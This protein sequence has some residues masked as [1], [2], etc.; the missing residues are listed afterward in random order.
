MPRVS[1]IVAVADNGVIGHQGDL[2]WR[3]S[4]DLKRL[5]ALTMGHHMIMGRRTW[6]TLPGPLPGRKIIVV[7]RSRDFVPPEGVL[8]AGS[9]ESALLLAQNDDEVFIAGG[10]EI[11]EQSLHRAD[12]MYL[13]RVHAE[14]EGD[15]F[16]PEFDDVNEWQ[17][18]DS[19][20]FDADEKNQYPFSFL[21]YERAG[22]E[23]HAVP[24]SG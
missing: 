7:T 24:E 9:V 16:F 11:F 20:H 18:A 2:P 12:R 10:A 22:A 8:A 1:I 4:A 17:L 19:E 6:D 15:T 14:P 3:Q 23:G 13:T 5:K 21:T